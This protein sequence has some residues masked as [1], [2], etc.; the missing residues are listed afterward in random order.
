MPET[1]TVKRAASD[2]VRSVL[3]G[4]AQLV[5]AL[6]AIVV[7]IMALGRPVGPL[8][9]RDR[10]YEA[11]VRGDLWGLERA[12][13]AYFADSG[14]YGASLAELNFTASENVTIRLSLAG[15][16]AWSAFGTHTRIPVRCTI[17]V[18]DIEPPIAGA[19]EHYP[20]CEE[21]Q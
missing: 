6:L 3:V 12:Q 9:A 1:P 5:A 13:D 16:S 8:T 19:E 15:D 2:V 10:A 11:A 18:G 20:T 4:T 14:S 7:T 21:T 17:F